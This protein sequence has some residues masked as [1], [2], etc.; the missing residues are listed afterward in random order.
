MT[1]ANQGVARWVKGLY[2]SAMVQN[3][4]ITSF[5][6][7]IMRGIV[8]NIRSFPQLQFSVTDGTQVASGKKK[9]AVYV[10]HVDKDLVPPEEFIGL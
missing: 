3:E 4:I 5:V 6:S 8:E 9:E 1:L 7:V 2:S 10:S